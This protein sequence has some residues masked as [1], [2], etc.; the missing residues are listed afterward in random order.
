MEETGRLGEV[1]KG[2]LAKVKVQWAEGCGK[3]KKKKDPYSDPFYSD[4][5]L[6]WG[7]YHR[8]ENIKALHMADWMDNLATACGNTFEVQSYYEIAHDKRFFEVVRQQNSYMYC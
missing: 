3:A 2:G 6:Y 8:K 4:P 5:F 7:S 1:L